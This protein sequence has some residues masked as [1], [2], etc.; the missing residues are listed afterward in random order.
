MVSNTFTITAAVSLGCGACGLGRLAVL[1]ESVQEELVFMT[2]EQDCVVP[3]E[4]LISL[5]AEGRDGKVG[6]P[7][8]G[9]SG[10][11]SHTRA[12]IFGSR[13]KSILAFSLVCGFLASTVA[14]FEI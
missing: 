6:Q 10:S 1:S 13:P 9:N 2:G 8:A 14:N 4:D 3:R 11:T 7:L 12:L 5:F